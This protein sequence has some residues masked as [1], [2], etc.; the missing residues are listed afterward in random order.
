MCVVRVYVTHYSRAPRQVLLP[1]SRSLSRALLSRSLLPCFSSGFCSRVRVPFPVLTTLVFLDR[2]LS[3]ARAL[4]PVFLD[5]FLF[6]FTLTRVPIVLTIL[7]LTSFCPHTPPTLLLP[8]HSSCPHTH[9][10]LL[11]SSRSSRSPPAVTTSLT[12]RAPPALTLAL[13]ACS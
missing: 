12:S 3:R 2:F 6:V 10:A 9:P 11:L 8:P 7:V 4:F 5:R 13:P 1:Y